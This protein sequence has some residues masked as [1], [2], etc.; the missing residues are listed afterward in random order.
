LIIRSDDVRFTPPVDARAAGRRDDRA[1]N[2]LPLVYSA[3]LAASGD[4]SVAEQVAER[5]MVAAG[6]GDATSLA[7]RAV[8]LALR[9]APHR[10]F[11]PMGA[12]ER[13]AVALA[14]LTRATTGRVAT[15]LGISQEEACA[16]MR[17][18]LRKCVSAGVGPRTPQ[19]RRGS[20]SA[21]SPGRVGRAS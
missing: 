20:G 8:L 15:V 6:G 19:L 16:R 13:E 1:M 17:S 4:R 21:A 18:G 5:V 7:E 3:A 12:E 11:A 9:V 10:A 2:R 14:R